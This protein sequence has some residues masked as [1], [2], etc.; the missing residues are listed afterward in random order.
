MGPSAA[1]RQ[2]RL[3]SGQ[4]AGG[5]DAANAAAVE[6]EDSLRPWSEE[7]SFDP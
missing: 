6:R 2:P 5:E 3:D 1:P 4:N 7:A